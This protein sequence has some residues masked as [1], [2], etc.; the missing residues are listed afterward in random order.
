VTGAV[1]GVAENAELAVAADQA[2]SRFVGDIDAE[3]RTSPDGLPDG[4]RRGLPFASTSSDS[5]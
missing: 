2:R 5:S 3:A 1:E 4:D